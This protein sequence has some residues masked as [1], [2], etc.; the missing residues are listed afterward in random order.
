MGDDLASLRVR[1]AGIDHERLAVAQHDADVLVVE[2][3]P[4]DEYAI[5][6]LDPPAGHGVVG[7]RHWAAWYDGA[8][9]SRAAASSGPASLRLMHVECIRRRLLRVPSLE[10]MHPI[11]IAPGR[12]PGLPGRTT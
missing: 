11:G 12:P 6:K 7:R 2:R 4:A 3:I 8:D 5:G 1:R 9:S 10:M